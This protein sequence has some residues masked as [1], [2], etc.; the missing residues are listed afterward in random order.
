MQYYFLIQFL[1]LLQVSLS[2]TIQ[3]KHQNKILTQLKAGGGFDSRSIPKPKV[4]V[5]SSGTKQNPNLEKFLMMYT[6]KICNGRNANMVSKVAY[7]NGI[8]IAKCK[9]CA[10]K[11]LIA[12]NQKKLDFPTHFGAKIEEYLISKGE[13]VQ[14]LSLT[15][16]E[17]EDNT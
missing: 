10:S 15:A 16:Q 8:V 14:K 3:N 2:L 12:D 9:T 4:I 11:H 7:Q 17:L 5:P 6:C 13:R 1:L